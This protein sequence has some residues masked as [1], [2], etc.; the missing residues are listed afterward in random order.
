MALLL[1]VAAGALILAACG[2]DDGGTGAGPS[3]TASADASGSPGATATGPA[4]TA[5]APPGTRVVGECAT[6]EVVQSP[7]A[8]PGSG[9]TAGLLSDLT[10]SGDDGQYAPGEEIGMTLTLTNCGDNNVRLYYPTSQR[11]VF[12][13][14][15]IDSGVEVW[16]SS[17]ELAFLQVEG[18]EVIPPEESLVY[19][20]TWDQLDRDGAQVPAARY[21]ISAFSVG[22]GA[23][24]QSECRFGPVQFVDITD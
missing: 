22:C 4:G 5:T 11:Y 3:A 21:K 2:D 9:L 12:I 10:F 20:E 8:S 24:S 15:D 6:P 1:A 23:E 19:E 17:D 13:A 16:R 18:Q 14:E 7:G